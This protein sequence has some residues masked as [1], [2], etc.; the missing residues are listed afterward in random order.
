[1]VISQESQAQ[2]SFKKAESLENIEKIYSHEVVKSDADKFNEAFVKTY[3]NQDPIR[4][5][6]LFNPMATE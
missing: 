3:R 1:M 6:R 2:L 4:G 5:K